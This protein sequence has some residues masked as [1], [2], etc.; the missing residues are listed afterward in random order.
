MMAYWGR[1]GIAPLILQLGTRRMQV[2]NFTP[3]CFTLDG[4]QSQFGCSGGER[5]LLPLLGYC[6]KW[7]CINEQRTINDVYAAVA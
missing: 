1:R 4:L 5:N 6:V 2:V 7:Y 3:A